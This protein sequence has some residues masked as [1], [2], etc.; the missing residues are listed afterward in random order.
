[1]VGKVDLEITKHKEIFA[2]PAPLGLIGLAI[3][4]AALT[5][6]AFGYGLE[7]AGIKATF[8]TAAMYA[9]LFGAGCQFLCGMMEYANKNTYGGT[10]FTTFA[11]N[12]FFNYWVFNSISD[13]MMPDHYTILAVEATMLVI[14]TALT[15]GFG[16]FSSLLFYFLLDIDILYVCKVIKALS[17]MPTLLNLP[18]AICTALL[19][20]IALWIALAA[21]I[22]PVAG[23]EVFKMSGPMFFAPKKTGFDF[24]LRYNIFEL[25]YK[26]WKEN[27]YK[28]MK[29]EEL[30]TAV[31]DKTG[32]AN[33]VPDLFYL[34]EFGYVVLNFDVF[35]K[36]KVIS[37][38][39]NAHGIDLYEQLILKKYDWR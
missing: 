14:F 19:G 16:F 38:R 21:L 3:A 1:M 10:I 34:Q 39:L 8:K 29:F 2:N 27:A 18:I 26:Y 35:E 23:R 32:N 33:I 20:L 13:G 30:Q 37:L 24:S 25:L 31:K 36:E 9:L 12:W 17:G 22:N 4:C 28:E 6:L 15:Y 7:P 5:P 11:F